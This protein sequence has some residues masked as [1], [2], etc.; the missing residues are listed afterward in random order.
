MIR[1]PRPTVGGAQSMSGAPMCV[2]AATPIVEMKA[3]PDQMR[4]GDPL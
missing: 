1:F 4:E 2:A 3:G